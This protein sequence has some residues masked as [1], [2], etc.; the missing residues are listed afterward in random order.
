[1][2]ARVSR[3]QASP[4]KVEA[5]IKQFTGSALPALRKMSGYAGHS[6]GVDR[7]S[8]DGQAVTFWESREALDA[9]EEAA[10]QVRTETTGAAEASVASVDRF[11][12][13]MMERAGPASAPAFI[14]V[15]RGKI[16]P[17]RL[18]DLARS[19]REEALPQVRSLAGFRALVL[20]VDRNSGKFAI[21][22]VWMTAE[23][24][25]ASLAAIDDIRRRT[26]ESVG[27]GEPELSN[28]EVVSVE[29]V[30]AGAVAGS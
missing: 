1:M 6:M 9:S 7:A 29:F 4:E 25:E 24:R 28:Y 19:M 11:E 21:T 16:D 15:N 20:G 3:V 14:R 2:Y 18:D 23:E 8:G 13:V 17:E 22:S 5:L 30:G 10:T 26:F 27:G 12:Q